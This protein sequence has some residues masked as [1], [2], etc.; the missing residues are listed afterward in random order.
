VLTE[1]LDE[2]LVL[3]FV[4]VIKGEE[5]LVARVRHVLELEGRPTL[6]REL[7]LHPYKRQPCVIGP[8]GRHLSQVIPRHYG[9]AESI[10]GIDHLNVRLLLP[11]VRTRVIDGKIDHSWNRP[12]EQG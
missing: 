7:L 1:S 8:P 3:H 6:A 12:L 5:G 2:L 4:L 11:L 10:W 9:S